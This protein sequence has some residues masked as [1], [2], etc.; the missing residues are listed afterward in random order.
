MTNLKYGLDQLLRLRPVSWRW[1]SEPEGKPQMGL[2]AQEV[3]QVLP[4]LVL[5]DADA[6]KPLG[7]NYMA[8]LPVMVKS[9]QEQQAQIQQQQRQIEQLQAR[10]TQ[11]E[12]AGKKRQ[13]G[14]P[15][16]RR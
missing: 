11:L 3:E 7:L 13:R 10:V 16:S 6:T 4:E 12:R 8:L 5:K 9:I 1:K 14:R 2:V 15:H